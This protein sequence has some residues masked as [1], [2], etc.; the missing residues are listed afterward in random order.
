MR[1]ILYYTGTFI[2]FGMPFWIIR[3]VLLVL[4]A[5]GSFDTNMAEIAF[6]TSRTISTINPLV[7]GLCYCFLKVINLVRTM[8]NPLF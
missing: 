7:N 8:L 3:R 4:K 2:T 5:L 1:N 6:V